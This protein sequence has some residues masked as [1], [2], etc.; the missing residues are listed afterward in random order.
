MF[1]IPA[2]PYQVEAFQASHSPGSVATAV[3]K[4]T[5]GEAHT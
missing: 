3:I 1:R 2:A 4:K 5:F